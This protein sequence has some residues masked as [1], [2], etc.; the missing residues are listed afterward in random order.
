[1]ILNGNQIE[2]AVRDKMNKNISFLG[3]LVDK[4]LKYIIPKK[5]LF[6]NHEAKKIF[7]I[8]LNN[9]LPLFKK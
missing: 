3:T 8:S 7:F 6:L 4:E 2:K 5:F 1:M 9:L